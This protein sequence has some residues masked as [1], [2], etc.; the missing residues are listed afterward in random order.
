MRSLESVAVTIGV[1]PEA[2]GTTAVGTGREIGPIATTTGESVVTE[3]TTV[4]IGAVE[5]TEAGTGSVVTIDATTETGMRT[6]A[7]TGIIRIGATIAEMTVTGTG[8]SVHVIGIM[9]SV[10]RTMLKKAG[11]TS[12]RRLSA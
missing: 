6:D 2:G 1:H 11:T 4:E 5:A 8:R 10:E 7:T 9:A 3:T 12:T